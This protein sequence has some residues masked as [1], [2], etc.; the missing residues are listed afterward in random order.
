LDGGAL[1]WS[2][3]EHGGG[4][5][6]TDM[7]GHA[8][9]H[10]DPPSRM[11]RD[12]ELGGIDPN[13]IVGD[14]IEWCRP[15]R[16]GIEPEEEVMHYRVSHQDCLEDLSPDDTCFGCERAHG[17]IDGRLNH[18]RQFRRS[19]LVH[20]DVRHPAHHVLTKPHLG[21]H[22]P[23][24]GQDL[25]GEEVTEMAGDGG[26]AHIEG[27]SEAAVVKPWPHRG[28]VGLVVDGDSDR[29]L[30]LD[31]GHL[32]VGEDSRIEPQPM[33]L[34]FVLQG[35]EKPALVAGRIPEY[36][37]GDLDVE[38]P[39]HRVDVDG[40]DLRSLSHH[41]AVHLAGC[42]DVDDHI[43]EDLHLTTETMSL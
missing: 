1:V 37:L 17:V 40:G 10:I 2:L 12:P 41:L 14:Q 31:Q 23:V 16:C 5:I 22:R 42:W 27:H 13:R 6:G 7:A 9:K 21:V 3:G 15:E 4:G 34:P 35:D 33:E 25:S 20:H 26:R 30:S 32:Q 11:N 43:V 29:R 24:C 18:P 39:D 28:D 19:S 8:R 38:Q 36:R